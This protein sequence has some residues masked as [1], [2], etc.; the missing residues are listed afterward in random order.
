MIQWGS[1]NLRG[2]IPPCKLRKQV[3]RTQRVDNNRNWKRRKLS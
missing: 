3:R 1:Q 2:Q